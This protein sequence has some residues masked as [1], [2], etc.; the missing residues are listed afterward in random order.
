MSEAPRKGRFWPTPAALGFLLA[1]IPLGYY[2][3]QLQGQIA[4]LKDQVNSNANTVAQL[5]ARVRANADTINKLAKQ[6]LPV[7]VATR[8]AL[9][10]GGRVLL[11]Q[12]LTSTELPVTAT[13][14]RAGAPSQTRELVIPP[15]G[16]QQ[17]GEREGWQFASGDSVKLSNP[18]YRDW[19][20]PNLVF[21]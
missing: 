20:N 11:I 21:N 10:S 7:R 17:I 15:N 4:Q 18:T 19:S 16:T 3:S 8:P 9:L 5:N 12:N 1:A 13:F 6:D 14:G 2:V